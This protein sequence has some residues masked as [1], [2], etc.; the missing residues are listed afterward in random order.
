M[1]SINLSVT[2]LLNLLLHAAVELYSYYDCN[3][4]PCK[5]QVIQCVSRHIDSPSL[6]KFLC[7]LC[8]SFV[9]LTEEFHLPPILQVHLNINII[10]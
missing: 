7:L 1:A 4:G 9:N 2:H 6:H 5:C 3:F 8:A 10:I